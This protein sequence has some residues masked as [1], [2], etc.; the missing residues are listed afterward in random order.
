[1]P[2]GRCRACWPSPPRRPHRVAR[3]TQRR[4]ADAA[5]SGAPLTLQ[6]VTSICG[7]PRMGAHRRLGLWLLQPTH[8]AGTHLPVVEGRRGVCTVM[9]S[10]RGQISS[11]GSCSTPKEAETSGEMMGSYPT[12]W[13]EGEGGECHSQPS[14][15][16]PLTVVTV[17]GAVSHHAPSATLS[18]LQTP[19][20]FSRQYNGVGATRLSCCCGAEGRGAHALWG[21]RGG[22]S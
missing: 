6:L 10:H 9:K 15:L 1:M 3:L 13:S 5:G 11:R 21:R 18:F 19:L 2:R 14:L 22:R 16:V 8:G 20:Y 7:G 4:H 17:Y 12:V